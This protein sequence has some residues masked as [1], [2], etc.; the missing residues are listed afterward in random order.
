LLIALYGSSAYYVAT[1]QTVHEAYVSNGQWVDLNITAATGTSSRVEV[2]A[3]LTMSNAAP[4]YVATDLTIHQMYTSN[5]QWI[6]FN[7]TAGTGTAARVASGTSLVLSGAAPYYVA[8]DQTVHQMYVSGSAWV[9]F[10]ITAG[11]GTAARVLIDYTVSGQVLAGSSGLPG[12]TVTLTGTTAA[13]ISVSL[14]TTTD[15][16]G[17]YSF[18]VSAGGTYTAV[19]FKSGYTV[20]P[21]SSVFNGVA[22]NQ[23][24]T[25]TASVQTGSLT[26][27]CSDISG[28]WTDGNYTYSLSETSGI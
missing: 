24:V 21:A 10:N 27:N 4:Y 14:S 9:D 13:G 3:G 16:N 25:S 6:D 5:G 20:S 18:A 15:S 22:A 11:T 12:A 28:T 26:Q 23:T 8:T 17:N 7:I 2:G 19:S 1:D